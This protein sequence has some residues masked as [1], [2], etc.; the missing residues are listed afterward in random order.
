MLSV[1]VH[2]HVYTALYVCECAGSS[3]VTHVCIMCHSQGTLVCACMGECVGAG[4]F[5]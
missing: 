4:L 2:M 5:S 3:G 1:C